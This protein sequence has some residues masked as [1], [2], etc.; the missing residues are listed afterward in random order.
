[1]CAKREESCVKDLKREQASRWRLREP[2][3]T[4]QPVFQNRLKRLQGRR[5]RSTP[6]L[7]TPLAHTQ[8]LRRCVGQAVCESLRLTT[9][10]GD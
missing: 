8:R 5:D 10:I 3:P 9:R 4:F 6:R 7:V 2:F 1:M